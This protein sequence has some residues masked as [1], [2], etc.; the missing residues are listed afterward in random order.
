[1]DAQHLIN[2]GIALF[3]SLQ[4]GDMPDEVFDAHKKAIAAAM[5]TGKKATVTVSIE[6]SVKRNK[7]GDIVSMESAVKTKLPA[8]KAEDDYFLHPGGKLSKTPDGQQDMEF[9]T[10][11]DKRPE[12]VD[13]K[14][15]DDKS[16][17]SV[18]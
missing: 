2:D 12:T 16:I 6:Y 3:A 15:E 17:R 8:L 11:I 13:T 5:D 1:M 10:K 14:T 7:N 9:E 18:K 4:R